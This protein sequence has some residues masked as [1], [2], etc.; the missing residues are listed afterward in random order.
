MTLLALLPATL[1]AYAAAAEGTDAKASYTV[2]VACHGENGEGNKALNAPRIGGQSAWYVERQLNNFRAGI[3]GGD[4][5]DIYGT[6]MKPMAMTL[7]DEA[8]VKAVAEYVSKLPGGKLEATVEGDVEK[9]EALY[10]TCRA[11]HGPD[12]RGMQALNSPALVGQSDWYIAR[13][14]KNFREGLRGTHKKDTYGAQ[15]RPMAMT[16]ADDAA[17]NALAA[18]IASLPE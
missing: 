1:F 3:R 12:G 5:K 9:G 8:A 4:P 17:I 10:A 13:Q 11:C 14:L 2:C 18:Y 16:L 15:M 7:S 6:Q